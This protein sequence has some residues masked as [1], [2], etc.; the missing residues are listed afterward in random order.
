MNQKKDKYLFANAMIVFNLDAN[1]AIDHIVQ[2]RRQVSE[3]FMK[4]MSNS[5][6]GKDRIVD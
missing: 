3:I 2:A 4:S 6:R 5:Q 1:K